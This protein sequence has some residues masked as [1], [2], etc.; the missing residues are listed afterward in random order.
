ME[1]TFF[2]TTLDRPPAHAESQQLPPAHHPVLPPGE[3]GD[4][5]VRASSP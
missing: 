1:S 3:A 5:P 2:D 4:R